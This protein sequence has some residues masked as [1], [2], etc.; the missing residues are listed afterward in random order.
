MHTATQDPLTELR[1]HFE[2]QIQELNARLSDQSVQG[3][4]SF[5]EPK[6]PPPD[7]FNGNLKDLKNFIASVNNIFTL[8]PSRYPTE[9]IKVRYVG[10]LLTGDAL[11]WFRTQAT[12]PNFMPNK[13]H[14]FWNLLTST[15]GDPCAQWTARNRLKLLKQGK[16][17]CVQYTTK[18]KHIALESGY[19][20]IA[21][22]QMYHD[23]LNDPIKDVLAQSLD[24]PSDLDTYAQLCIKLDNR[25][26]ARRMEKGASHSG[27]QF[28]QPP[29]PSH[30][31]AMSHSGPVPMQLDVIQAYP[32]LTPEQKQSR[33]SQG[34][35]LY[36]GVPGH[37][38]KAC[39]KKAKP[40]NPKA[41]V[42]TH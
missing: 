40:A 37:F 4:S 36:C 5:K 42:Q 3:S 22:L 38:A 29:R 7:K 34:L 1:L 28:K 23:G 12:P 26:F 21:L 32:K 11:T 8:Q 31:A 20:S 27:F 41:K 18:F 35:C 9:E 13:L 33:I 39:P 24:V 16:L 6:L 15:F 14:A 19:D 25:Q 2:A 30:P 10:T 17:S